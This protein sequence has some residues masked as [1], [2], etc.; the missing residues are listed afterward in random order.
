MT[1]VSLLK[2]KLKGGKISLYL[3]YYPYIINPETG[4]KTRREYLRLY[5]TENP[6]NK[7]ERREN[8]KIYSLADIILSKRKTQLFNKEYGFAENVKLKVDFIEFFRKIVDHRYNIDR[9]YASFSSAFQY[10]VEFT[11]GR[12]LFSNEID[13]ELIKEFR[14]YLLK[15]NHLKN[16]EFKLGVNTASSYYKNFISVL[17][18]A[19]LKKII[20]KDILDSIEF[21][22]EEDTYREYL[23]EEELSLLWKTKCESDQ[24][25]RIAFFSVYTGLR[26]GDIQKLTWDKIFTDNVQGFYINLNT[27]KTKSKDNLPNPEEAY[28][29]LKQEGTS[30]GIIFNGLNYS[31]IQRPLRNWIKESGITKHITFHNFRHTFATLQLANGTDIY[32]VS[33]LL[34]HKNIST[35]QIYAKVIDKTK[36]ESTNKIKLNIGLE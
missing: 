2:R 5:P 12:K 4:E 35:T 11:E 13:R 10:F 25:R 3:S 32:T 28:K 1:T 34:G 30:E 9:N 21:I 23:T 7:T 24:L 17:K 19:S 31:E 33:K 36:I 15:A 27:S 18:E 8:E 16:K 29:L 6:K 14:A 26:F 20:D 22:K